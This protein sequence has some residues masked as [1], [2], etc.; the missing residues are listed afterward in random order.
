MRGERSSAV[1]FLAVPALLGWACGALADEPDRR[2]GESRPGAT[3]SAAHKQTEQPAGSTKESVKITTTESTT[4]ESW[5]ISGPITLR[6]A[7]PEPTGEA[8][9]KNIFSWEHSRK[10]GE[11]DDF[12]DIFTWASGD[13]PSEERDEY[14]YELEVEYGLA[15]N[16]ELIL[17]I[18]VQVGDG[19]VDGN[20]DLELGWHWRLWKETDSWPAFAVRNY[21]RVP[22]GVGSSGVDYWIRGLFTKTL[23]PGS[24]RLHFNPWAKTVNGDN[25]PEARPFQWGALL[26]VD[27]RISDEWLFV[28]DYKYENGEDEGTRDNHSAELDLDWQMT[29]RQKLGLCTEISL[30][31]DNS[32][33]A[34]AVKISYMLEF[35]GS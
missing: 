20:G 28:S 11:K 19:R 34:V 9:V 25:E 2:A 15:E 18:P 26:G 21:V 27:Y 16:H 31:G 17:A 24:T 23:I 8:V 35:G 3:V 13:E 12:S 5:E 4:A 30:D 32:G 6:S 22:T 10:A 29:E 1:I 7:D 14:E 33:P